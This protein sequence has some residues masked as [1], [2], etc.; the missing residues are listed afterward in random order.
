[1]AV[2]WDESLPDGSTQ[3]VRELDDDARATKIALRQVIEVEHEGPTATDHGRHKPGS[4]KALI[5]T[6]ANIL[7]LDPSAVE[8]ANAIAFATDTGDLLISDGT[9]WQRVAREPVGTIK[10]WP[11]DAVPANYLALDGSVHLVA[12]YPVLGALLGATYGGDGVTDFGVPDWR[13][14]VVFGLDPLDTDFDDVTDAGG[15]KDHNHGGVTGPSP[16]LNTDLSGAGVFAPG[17]HTHTIAT[18]SS[19]PP[20][21]VGRWVVRAK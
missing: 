9:A 5:D 7:A 11:M 16:N 19:L 6:D 18:D 4:A 2:T 8:N 1:M 3:A 20:Y 15:A 10:P 17:G 13:G 14:K 21:A 12:T